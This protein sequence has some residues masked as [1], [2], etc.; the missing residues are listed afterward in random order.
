MNKNYVFC[1]RTYWNLCWNKDTCICISVKSFYLLRANKELIKCVNVNH[2][3]RNLSLMPVFKVNGQHHD[4][5]KTNQVCLSPFS[6][7]HNVTSYPIFD[8]FIW[9]VLHSYFN[10]TPPKLVWKWI[11]TYLFSSVGP[12]ICCALMCRWQRSHLFRL[13]TLNRVEPDCVLF[14]PNLSSVNSLSHIR[15]LRKC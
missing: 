15:P 7:S 5:E 1:D 6:W 13:T 11:E 4:Y 9:S 3:H 8:L 2:I 12:L 14:K 10:W